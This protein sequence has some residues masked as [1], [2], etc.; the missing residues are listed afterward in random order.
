MKVCHLT[1][2]HV[3]FDTRVFT[4]ECRSLARAGHEVHL[5]AGHAKDEICDGVCLHSVHKYP[6][7]LKRMTVTVSRVYRKALE[8]DADIYHFHDPELVLVGLL[9]KLRGKRVIYDIHEDYSSWLTFNEGI[10]PWLRN[11]AARAFT[12]LEGLAVR[13]F[14]ALVTVTPSIFHHFSAMNR[15]TVLVRN[16]PREEEFAPDGGGEIPWESRENAVCYIGGIFPKRGLAEMIR[17]ISLVRESI[18]AKLLLGGDVTPAARELLDRL[19]AREMEG[20]ECFGRVSRSQIADI[21][22]RSKAG[23]TIL[24]PER[25]FLVSYPTKMFEYMS[26]GLPVIC[27]DF[28]LFRELDEGTNACLFVD[29]L[30]PVALADAILFLFTHREEAEAIGRRGRTAIR[31]RYNWDSEERTLLELYESVMKQGEGKRK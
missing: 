13:R 20:V 12:G 8:I 28:P 26:A 30:D 1:S 19:P 18:P 6:G 7:R 27:S 29:P 3:P 31:E 21:F 9:L 16:F 15:R 24:H 11:P 22:R 10:P 25:N 23:L 5:V 17:A 14:D 4:K 2:V